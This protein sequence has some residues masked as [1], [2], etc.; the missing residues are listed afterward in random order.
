MSDSLNKRIEDFS[1]IARHGKTTR[2]GFMK[3]T[4]LGI[5]SVAA[6]GLLSACGEEPD[7]EDD[8]EAAPAAEPEDDDTDVAVDDTDEDDTVDEVED[9][10]TEEEPDVEDEA[11]DTD[12][13][14]DGDIQSGG[15]FRLGFD[16]S[17]LGFD[18]HA[19]TNFA[20]LNIYENVYDSLFEID[21]DL[22]L[23]PTLCESYE[24]VDDVTYQFS[25]REGVTFHDGKEFTAEDVKYSYERMID[26]EN[27]F[28]RVQWFGRLESVE[29]DDDYTCTFTLQETFAPFVS[30]MGMQGAAIVDQNMVEEYGDLMDVESAN[31][32]G[33]FRLVSYEPDREARL[34]RFEDHWREDGPYIDEIQWMIQSDESS[35]VAAI[36]ADESD[37][38]RL[39]DV[40]NAQVLGEEFEVHREFVTS[41]ALTIINCRREP[42]DNPQVRQAIA[43]AINRQDFIE[44]AMFGEAEPAGYLPPS[45]PAAVPVEE[46]DTF[47]QDID[48]ARELLEEAGYEDGFEIHLVASPQYAMDISNAE[49]LQ[50]QLREINIEVNIE[51]LEW[52]TLLDNMRGERDFDM[53]N[54]IF[55]FQPD[56][57]GYLYQYFHTDSSDNHS[58]ISDPEIDDLIE[59]GRTTVD[60]DER[61]EIYRELQVRLADE[62]VP[63]LTYFVYYQ[64]FPTQERVRGWTMNPSISYRGLRNVWLED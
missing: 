46:F 37:M 2:R 47:T 16:T 27:A 22:E 54:I 63:K 21:E 24:V 55:T 5:G 57:D 42:L 15:T 48:R 14:D 43:Y 33:P 60:E 31:G 45:M 52:G 10:D 20:S 7:A 44:A 51:Q 32:T 34:E 39:F 36:R 13:V 23:V 53:L 61:N 25:L 1:A 26:P 3:L 41:R 38:V 62:W 19:A 58:G 11:E 12:D 40:Q 50:N 56:P 35:R 59:Q 49:V 8:D 29:I 4:G 30:Y 18:P 17:P 9:E 28:P 6:L 64:Y